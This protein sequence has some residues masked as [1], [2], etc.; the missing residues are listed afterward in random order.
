[1]EILSQKY[2]GIWS[3]TQI[4]SHDA[5]GFTQHPA[6]HTPIR[7]NLGT[8]RLTGRIV[9][10]AGDQQTDQQFAEELDEIVGHAER[11]HQEIKE[12][13]DELLAEKLWPLPTAAEHEDLEPTLLEGDD[14][15]PSPGLAKLIRDVRLVNDLPTAA[16]DEDLEPTLLE[17]NVDRLVD[18]TLGDVDN[19]TRE[20]AKKIARSLLGVLELGKGLGT[21]TLRI[22][23]EK[24]RETVRERDKTI[25]HL[26]EVSQGLGERINALHSEPTEPTPPANPSDEFRR[27]E[28]VELVNAMLAGASFELIRDIDGETAMWIQHLPSRGSVQVF[29]QITHEQLVE[30]SPAQL[31]GFVKS[32]VGVS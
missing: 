15:V 28:A 29:L 1:M 8:L 6:D 11:V 4:P 26:R 14:G 25:A 3:Y 16:D 23:A 10:L 30:F 17:A 19:G 24:L 2:G 12:K 7:L 32:Q 9:A 13:P 21:D 20:H 22:E 31:F 5:Y 18:Q 27:A